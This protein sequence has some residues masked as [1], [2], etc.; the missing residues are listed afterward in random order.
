[1]NENLPARRRI[2][3]PDAIALGA[4]RAPP[5]ERAL[6]ARRPWLLQDRRTAA[7]I[8]AGYVDLFAVRMEGGVPAGPRQ[9]L[10]R[11]DLGGLLLGIGPAAVGTDGEGVGVLAVGGQGAI[12]DMLD[13]HAVD[14]ALLEAWICR[15]SAAMLNAPAGWEVRAAEAGTRLALAEGERFR[16]PAQGVAWVVVE[17]GEVRL[18]DAACGCASG[19]PPVPLAAGTWVEGAPSGAAVAVLPSHAL[20]GAELATA[21]DAFHD[22]AIECVARRLADAAEAK[23]RHAERRS[24]LAATQAGELTGDLARVILP[25]RR[26][27]EGRVEAGDP[28]FAA[29]HIAA[30]ALGAVVVHP[31]GDVAGHGFGGVLDIARASRLR[32]REVLLRS[33]WWRGNVGPLVAWH[34]ETRRPV[35]IVASG[36]R[37]SAMVD[38]LSGAH[39]V[40]DARLASEL[41]PSAAMLYPS[42]PQRPLS[43]VDLL[44]FCGGRIVKDAA[45]ILLAALALGCWRWRCR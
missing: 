40:V 10:F 11:V 28:L 30:E 14:P 25:R 44:R 22:R 38:A 15:L 23:T 1:M 35:A 9:H 5:E 8:I 34:G 32:A 21:M 36:T 33:G 18:A 24:A 16:A 3:L 12:A 37:R 19:H 31:P 42:L 4:T 39:R 20:A 2:L 17:S 7:R 41:N 43:A 13:R 29:C 27:H 45:R 6:D 26:R